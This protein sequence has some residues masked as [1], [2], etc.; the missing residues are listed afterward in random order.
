[1]A[2]TEVKFLAVVILNSDAP[3]KLVAFY[4]DALGLPLARRDASENFTCV[5]GDTFFA[6]HALQE[7]KQP[8]QGVEVGFHFSDVD[9]FVKQLESKGVQIQDP[10][11][12]YPWA[13]AAQ[14]V[15]PQGNTVYLMQ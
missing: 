5:I 15:D 12:D 3:E 9:G 10:V 14:V 13:R 1:M 8:T 4:R 11:K 6:I 7:G 2:K